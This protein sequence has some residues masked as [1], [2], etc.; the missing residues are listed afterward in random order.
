[1]STTIEREDYLRVE[2]SYAQLKQY[3]MIEPHLTTQEEVE[4]TI[5]QMSSRKA[6]GLDNIPF[7]AIKLMGKEATEELVRIINA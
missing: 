6:P 7:R 2:E 1:M 3:R 4:T 5:N